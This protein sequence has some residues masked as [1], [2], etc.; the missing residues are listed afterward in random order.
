MKGSK[1]E[2]PVTRPLEGPASEHDHNQTATSKKPPTNAVVGTRRVARGGTGATDARDIRPR[3][4]Q[5]DG[6]LNGDPKPFG[7][8]EFLKY[9]DEKQAELW[10]VFH[11][12]VSPPPPSLLS[13]RSLSPLPCVFS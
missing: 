13:M 11:D 9:A 8:D 10:R 6:R 5:S 2:G 12:L 1:H 4:A 7:W 3:A